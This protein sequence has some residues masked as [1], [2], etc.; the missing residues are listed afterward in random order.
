MSETPATKQK[1]ASRAQLDEKRIEL[2][3]SRKRASKQAEEM[4]YR[5]E[6]S[7]DK[8][9]ALEEKLK[10]LELENEKLRGKANIDVG[11]VRA[12][13][14]ELEN[15]LELLKADTETQ[16]RNRDMK[17]LELKRKIDTLEFDMES[18]QLKERKT[19]DNNYAMEERMDR[20]INTLRRAIG[21]LESEDAP[22]R[23]LEALKKNLD[24]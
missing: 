9:R 15:K 12:R 14:R 24:V 11:R 21:E 6:L 10:R 5:A 16:I 23:N 7:E 8:A 1:S 4:R 3:V 19:V 13:E 17:I 22:I 2:E 20:V 18:I